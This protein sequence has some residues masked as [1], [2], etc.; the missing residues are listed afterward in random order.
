[1]LSWE[2]RSMAKQ[3]VKCLLHRQGQQAPEF[4]LPAGP[5]FLWQ[6]RPS[7]PVYTLVHEINAYAYPH[8]RV[9][10]EV[11]QS[12]SLTSCFA[13]LSGCG[14]ELSGTSGSLHSPGYPNT[15]PSN[16]ECIW[17]IHTTPGSSIQLT[18]QEFDIEYHPNCDYDVLE[19]RELDLVSKNTQIIC[20]SVFCRSR[21]NSLL[22]LLISAVARVM[23]HKR[24]K[25]HSALSSF[26]FYAFGVGIP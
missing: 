6:R 10:S 20:F 4:L 13:L 24:H 21:R 5:Q 25:S 3:R 18:I 9:V 16:R 2:A 14:G 15:Y 22:Q 26:Y 7:S 23:F 11:F 8:Y 19:V 17:Y 1:M 12:P